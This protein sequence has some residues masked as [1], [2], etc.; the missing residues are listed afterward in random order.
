MKTTHY[1]IFAFLFLLASCSGAE[2]QPTARHIIVIG[3]DGMSP[4]GVRKADTPHMDEMMEKGAWTLSAR[5]VLPS[6]SSPNWAS[7]IMG[8]GPE[9]HGIT[10]NSWR[11]D[12][13]VLPTMV[14][15]SA[16]FFPTI[17]RIAED[18]KPDLEVGIVY[19]WTGFNNLFDRSV[20]DY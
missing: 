15:G 19:H 14:S 13:H 20:P 7:M 2:Q 6:S 4:D 16:A 17:F 12:Q 11:E 5:G 1:L 10:S 8:A 9:Q 3:V 18:Q